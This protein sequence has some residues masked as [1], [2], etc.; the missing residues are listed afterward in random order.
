MKCSGYFTAFITLLYTLLPM[1][2]QSSKK[3]VGE[4]CLTLLKPTHPPPLLLLRASLRI[5]IFFG[6]EN[7]L[8]VS[9]SFVRVPSF[10]VVYKC[11]SVLNSMTTKS[12]QVILL[13]GDQIKVI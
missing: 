5:S 12:K 3:Q 7:Q 4:M 2:H 10:F 11:V 8:R 9:E 1:S 13:L 6:S